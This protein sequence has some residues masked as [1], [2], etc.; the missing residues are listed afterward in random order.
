[1]DIVFLIIGL[2]L[3]LIDIFLKIRTLKENIFKRIFFIVFGLATLY[4]VDKTFLYIS[5]R[6][7]FCGLIIGIVFMG[8][9]ILVAKG[10]KLKK[11]NVNKGLIYTS[12]LI[13]GL[14]LPA[15]EFLY[16][17]IILIPLLKL[18]QP[19]VAIS[20]TSVLFLGLHLK[21]WNNKFVWIGSLVLGVICAI[22]VYLTKSI[23]AA[24]IIHNLNDFGFMTLVN[25]KNIF[26][27]KY[28]D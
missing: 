15:E 12:L 22:S 23:W 19:I 10:V 9:H 28:A 17:G 2:A 5:T 21:T 27:E 4:F 7:I 16:R 13:Y 3:T 18:F 8:I 25:K 24:I 11:E 26:K 6:A 1:M 14:E 20:L